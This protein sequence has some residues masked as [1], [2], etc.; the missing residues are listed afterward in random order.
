[1]GP[2][3][4]HP[5]AGPG[6]HRRAAPQL[7]GNRQHRGDGPDEARTPP[8]RRLAARKDQPMTWYEIKNAAAAEADI[9]LYN[10]IGFFG[11]TAEQFVAELSRVTAPTINVHVNSYGG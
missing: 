2:Q 1:A 8:P 11:V 5:A 7:V 6:A 10:D 3:A 4:D 9:Y